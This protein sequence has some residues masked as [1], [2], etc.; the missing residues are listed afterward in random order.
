MYKQPSLKEIQRNLKVEEVVRRSGCSE[1]Q[2]RRELIAE[3]WDTA[4][5]LI[6][7]HQAQSQGDI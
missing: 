7:I 5:A 6:N 1:Q 2:A 3:E 4:E